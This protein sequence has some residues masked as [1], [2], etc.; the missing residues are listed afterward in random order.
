MVRTGGHEPGRTGGGFGAARGSSRRG[1]EEPCA[2]RFLQFRTRSV[3]VRPVSEPGLGAPEG[4]D[5]PPLAKELQQPARR[6]RPSAAFTGRRVGRIA[7]GVLLGAAVGTGGGWTLDDRAAAEHRSRLHVDGGHVQTHVAM[8][9]RSL[10]SSLVQGPFEVEASIA[11]AQDQLQ[12]AR[13]ELNSLVSS[14]Q[15]AAAERAGQLARTALNDAT[16]DADQ[17]TARDIHPG[18]IPDRARLKNKTPR[19]VAIS[20]GPVLYSRHVQSCREVSSRSR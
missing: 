19:D 16:S 5:C 8:A 4:A 1:P 3:D 11:A 7:V 13:D 10:L 14:A 18:T 15:S 2:A 17:F 6:R 20:R 9:E 12:T